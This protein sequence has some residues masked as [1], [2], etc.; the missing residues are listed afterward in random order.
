[1]VFL[2]GLMSLCHVGEEICLGQYVFGSVDVFSVGGKDSVGYTSGSHS[3]PH[4]L[5]GFYQLGC[6]L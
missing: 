1:M 6:L 2:Y 4:K 3:L 5:V